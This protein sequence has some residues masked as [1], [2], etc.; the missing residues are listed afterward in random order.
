MDSLS[1]RADKALEMIWFHPFVAP[2][3]GNISLALSL[4]DLNVIII[5]GYSLNKNIL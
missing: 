2:F 5:K 4:K 3:F 1:A